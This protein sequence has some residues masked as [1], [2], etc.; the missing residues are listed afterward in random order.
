MSGGPGRRLFSL[1]GRRRA[2]RAQDDS[3]SQIAR[4]RA[5]RLASLGTGLG[6]LSH[7]LRGVLS[8]ALL[9][10]ERLQMHPDPAARRG[11]DVLVRAVDR[12]MALLRERLGPLREG[13]PVAARASVSLRELIEAAAPAGLVLVHDLPAACM[14]E[15]D[16]AYLRQAWECL[17]AYL[18]RAGAARVAISSAAENRRCIVTVEHDGKLPSNPDPFAIPAEASASFDLAIVRDLARACGGDLTAQ[19]GGMLVMA[20][21]L[22]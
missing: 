12:A 16:P 4:W 18:A 13:L 6:R 20:L 22:P 1:P 8:P 14:V 7:D 15:A 11:G 19:D 2:R 5:A 17:F 9:A 3:E 10:A 21:A